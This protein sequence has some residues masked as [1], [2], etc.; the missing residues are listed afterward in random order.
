MCRIPQDSVWFKYDDEVS[1]ALS[2]SDSDAEL[3][4]EASKD[5]GNV[6]TTEG[7]RAMFRARSTVVGLKAE[8]EGKSISLEANCWKDSAGALPRPGT[9]CTPSLRTAAHA[10][11]VHR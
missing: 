2:S 7:I 11:A 8:Y 4:F 10:T 6:L 3:I 1:R 9:S 5:D